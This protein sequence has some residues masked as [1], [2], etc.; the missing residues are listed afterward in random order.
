MTTNIAD[1][2]P[3]APADYESSLT[4]E[5][6]P[7]F[8]LAIVLGLIAGMVV[9]PYWLP[10]L[11]QSLSGASPKVYWYLSRGS[12]FVGMGLL[13]GS[14]M[15]GVGITNKMA[16]L[17]PGAPAAFAIHE[18]LS[19]LGLAFACFHAL[20]LLGDQ[21]SKYQL[22]QLLVPFGSVQYRPAWVGLGQLGFYAWAILTATF[23]VRKQIGQKTWRVI[24]Y[25]SFLCYVIALIHGLTSG[26]DAGLSLAQ[27]FYWVTG[28]SFLF[29]LVYRILTSRKVERNPTRS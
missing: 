16:R 15:L 13:W 8:L 2:N 9:L 14:M 17:W 10:G 11:A 23:Y 6:V 21:Y 27:D 25:G 28:G 18:Y 12:G 24:H 26:T 5:A 20:I 7:V 3:A 29:L 1:R 4:I 22:V 19:L